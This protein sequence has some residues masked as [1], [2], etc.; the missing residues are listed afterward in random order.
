MIRK[1]GIRKMKP[2]HIII[3]MAILL[4]SFDWL[5]VNAY[6]GIAIG[7]IGLAL[8]VIGASEKDK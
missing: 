5:F 2:K 1:D 3:G 4:F 8:V 6:L 7:G